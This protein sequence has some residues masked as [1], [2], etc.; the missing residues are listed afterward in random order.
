MKTEKKILFITEFQTTWWAFMNEIFYLKE[1][2]FTCTITD[3]LEEAK[4]IVDA[5][6]DKVVMFPMFISWL[7]YEINDD[8]IDEDTMKFF[9]GYF[10][11]K[12]E[13]EEKK[14]PTII[15]NIYD[16]YS[17]VTEAMT[18]L[19]KKDWKEN[20]NVTFFETIFDPREN[21]LKL[22]ELITS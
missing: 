18:N 2:G 1:Q 17:Y 11:W 22:V 13:L 7:N 8:T 9:T 3:S 6:V 4:K 15:V 14:I 12:Q 16:T 19:T 20:P 10:F 21:T 5:G